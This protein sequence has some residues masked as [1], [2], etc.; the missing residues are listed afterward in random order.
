[1]ANRRG[2]GE[3]FV[4]PAVYTRGPQTLG[5]S[6]ET[7]RRGAYSATNKAARIARRMCRVTQRPNEGGAA[8]WFGAFGAFVALNAALGFEELE[9]R[10][11][12][13]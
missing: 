10:E 3:S 12:E 4:P 7:G 1:M 11:H 13:K 5:M 2:A 9:G 8:P 6:V